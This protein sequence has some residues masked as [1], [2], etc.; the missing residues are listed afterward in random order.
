METGII[1]ANGNDKTLNELALQY[2]GHVVTSFCSSITT[3]V[4]SFNGV[5]LVVSISGFFA[6]FGRQMLTQHLIPSVLVLVFFTV[7]YLMTIVTKL[8]LQR[9]TYS[10]MT[11]FR[12]AIL[13][14]LPYQHVE[15]SN[16]GYGALLTLA[17]SVLLSFV[18][19][20]GLIIY[21]FIETV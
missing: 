19:G 3:N 2:H 4:A 9:Y 14:D 18:G 12:K 20:I 16:S 11:A 6:P 17:F 10:W 15:N 13:H 21:L 7:G 1:R 8:M 5:L